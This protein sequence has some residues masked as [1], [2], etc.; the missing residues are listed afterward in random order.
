M[1]KFIFVL[2]V[3]VFAMETKAVLD[4][5]GADN[6]CTESGTNILF[7]ACYDSGAGIRV[8]YTTD[9]G[10][11]NICK[12]GV[13]T[14][15]SAGTYTVQV[16]GASFVVPSSTSEA[17][18]ISLSGTGTTMIWAQPPTAVTCP[19]CG[20]SPLNQ[21]AVGETCVNDPK[22]KTQVKCETS[23]GNG[24]NGDNGGNGGDTT[25]CESQS[26]IGMP[27]STEGAF[28]L[29]TSTNAVDSQQCLMVKD[30]D[31][32]D[33]N[34]YTVYSSVET[35]GITYVYKDAKCEN[36]ATT[37]TL[38]VDKVLGSTSTTTSTTTLT[39]S[40]LTTCAGAAS[41]AASSSALTTPARCMAGAAVAMG[42][43]ATLF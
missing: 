20:K 30:C 12:C 39:C 18:T 35:A 8:A 9:G 5:H 17:G 32:S 26:D 11:L 13:F 10:S 31:S 42:A 27:C 33:R 25:E 41:S 43:I 15:C 7:D 4:S 19:V 29:G 14:A 1:L 16:E 23:G 3:V 38:E 28:C 22:A 6:A 40:L 21:C 24:G 2:S 37:L 36:D 34:K